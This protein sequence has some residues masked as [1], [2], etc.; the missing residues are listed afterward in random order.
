MPEQ[1]DWYARNM[2]KGSPQYEYHCRTEN[3]LTE[4][5]QF[6]MA[7]AWDS[8]PSRRPAPGLGCRYTPGSSS[9]CHFER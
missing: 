3:T 5:H 7:K 4:I 9:P 6:R 8:R 2:Y 1:G